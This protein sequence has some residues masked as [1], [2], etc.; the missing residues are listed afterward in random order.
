MKKVIFHCVL[1]LALVLAYSAGFP[2]GQ[3][4]LPATQAS[5]SVT[6]ISP[7]LQALISADPLRPLPV[8]MQT[9]NPP[10]LN[11]LSSITLLGGVITRSYQNLNALAAVLPGTLISILAARA[12]VTYI[13]L[14][15][16]TQTTG[17]LETTTGAGQAR[18]YGTSTSQ[19]NGSGIGIAILDSGI[20]ADHR[21]F[22]AANSTSRVRAS[23]DFT[24]ESRTDDPYGHGT[25]VAAIAAGNNQISQGAYTGLAPAASLINVR[26][27]DSRG[28]GSTSN[29]LAGIDWCISN[30]S[31][32]S[33]RV[34]NL[35]FG[36][37]AI[38]SYVNDPLCKAVRKA[39]DAGL[40][41][42]V[43][44]GNL[45]KDAQGVKLYGAIHSPGIEPSAITVGAANTFGSDPRTDDSITSYS[46][47][48]PTLGY[49]TDSN[50]DKHFD[51]LV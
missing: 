10:N 35:S 22:R 49:S 27:L 39:F 17:H 36:T 44:A 32:Y 50:G 38:D 41:V 19:I 13:S 18:G 37:L 7:D 14:D 48:G 40:V 1:V 33:I 47:R 29:A 43:A 46:T 31:A 21:A 26:V 23:V 34:L 9:V 24:G 15:R 6:R 5:L 12:D 45:G 42:C 8:I 28:R 2:F 16:P 4:S 25:H 3:K 30:R 51:N 11:L 20:Y